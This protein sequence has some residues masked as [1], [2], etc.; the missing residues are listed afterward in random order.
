MNTKGTH[1]VSDGLPVDFLDARAAW[2]RAARPILQ[3]VAWHYN[4]T[5]T[6]QELADESQDRLASAPTCRCGTGSER[7]FMPWPRM[8]ISGRNPRIRAARAR[9]DYRRRLRRRDQK[10]VGEIVTE[11]LIEERAARERFACYKYFGAVMPADGGRPTRTKEVAAKRE[12]ARRRKEPQPQRVACPTCHLV[13]PMSG[14]CDN[15][16][17][18]ILKRGVC[19]LAEC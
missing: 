18:Q 5:I 16:L 12:R 13:L 8:T 14:R 6:D 11:P 2:A 3:R 15:C 10:Y 1:R 7:R 17:P 9:R 19:G 4:A